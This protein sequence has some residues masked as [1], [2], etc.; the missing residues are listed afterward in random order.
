MELA[1]IRWRRVIYR[2]PPSAR[3]LFYLFYREKGFP[4][5]IWFSLWLLQYSGVL[6][7]WR[8]QSSFFTLHTSFP[9]RCNC[10]R[11]IYRRV[12]W[13]CAPLAGNRWADIFPI[14]ALSA[15]DGLKLGA[16]KKPFPLGLTYL[17]CKRVMLELLR[18]SCRRHFKTFRIL[19]VYSIYM[20]KC[21]FNLQQMY[22]YSHFSRWIFK[23][24]WLYLSYVKEFLVQ[25]EICNHE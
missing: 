18:D 23:T 6:R 20:L 14:K 21:C 12:L 24:F 8:G 13:R 3:P 4:L 11:R 19:T 15:S 2:A 16:L 17:K 5:S 22:Q 10:I 7:S 25:L 1:G 9:Q